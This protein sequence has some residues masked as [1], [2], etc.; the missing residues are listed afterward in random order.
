ME[1]IFK[2]QNWEV[3][4]GETMLSVIKSI[5]P[6]LPDEE[7]AKT[8][9]DSKRE[10]VYLTPEQKLMTELIEKSCPKGKEPEIEISFASTKEEDGREPTLNFEI[11][12]TIKRSGHGQAEVSK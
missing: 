7:I 11:K 1:K 10:E 12:K 4:I 9:L 8:I 5:Y 3:K 2:F 6:N